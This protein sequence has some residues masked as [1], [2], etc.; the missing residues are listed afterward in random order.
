VLRAL[1]LC[2]PAAAAGAPLPAPAADTRSLAAEVPAGPLAQALAAFGKQTG[3][4]VIYVAA[5]ADA[6]VSRGARAGSAL[7]DAL[8]QLLDGTGLRFEF[9]NPRT[10]RVYAAAVP[11]LA[12]RPPAEAAPP[13]DYRGQAR[14]ATV[15]EV[16]VTAS[17]REERSQ[18]VPISIQVLTGETLTRLNASTFDDFVK[19]LPGITTQGAGPAQNN[20]VIRGLATAAL[21]QQGSGTLGSFPNVAVYLDEQSVELA[22]RNLDVY[23][24][25]LERIEVLEGPQGTLF[26]SGAQAGVVRYITNKPKLDVTEGT[27]S[28]ALGRTTH[29]GTSTD[30]SAVINAPL[31]P[32]RLA[33]RGVLYSEQRAGYIDNVSGT[34]TRAS[35]D[36]A[37]QHFYT[38]WGVLPSFGPALD[39]AAVV[40]AHSNP[41]A[42]HGL[43]LSAL[44]RFNDDWSALLAQSFQNIDADG[45][46]AQMAANSAGEPLPDLSVQEFNRSYNKD[47]FSNTALTVS[48]RIGDV[49]ILYAGAYLVRHVDQVQDYTSYARASYA[50]YYQCIPLPS[51]QCF[52][53]SGVWRELERNTRQ[54]HELR[55]T[56]PADRRVRGVGGLYFEELGVEEQWDDDIRSASDFFNPMAPPTGYCTYN[57]S[58]TFPDGSPV[59]CY[60]SPTFV[61]A[62]ATSNNPSVRPAVDGFF[63][64]ITRRYRQFAAFASVDADIVPRTLT[65]TAGTRYFRVEGSEVGSSVSSYGC[66][67]VT[68]YNV[69]NPC[70]N[71][72]AFNLDAAGLT[73]QYSGF[74][75]RLSLGWRIADDALIYY[76]WSQGFRAG[77]FNRTGYPGGNSPLAAEGNSWQAQAGAHGGWIA[78]IAFAPDD[79]TNNELGWKS[80]WLD[81]RLRW[82]GAV[83]QEHWDHAQVGVAGNRLIAYRMVIDGG[84]YR[85]RG[86]E[87]SAEA[88]ILRG[89][90][91][92]AS[93]AWNHTELVRQA[94][95]YWA[96]GTPVDFNSLYFSDGTRATNPSGELGS[97]LAGAP[98]FAGNARIRYEFEL[99]PFGA[100]AQAGAVWQAHS[101][102]STDR[103]NQ[104][105]QGHSTAYD[106]PAFTTFEAAFGMGKGAWQLKINGENLTDTRAQ[107][108]ASYAQWYKAVTV[109][110]PRTISMQLDYH[111]GGP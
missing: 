99:G 63:D 33:V 1:A 18:D 66:S 49:S 2:A 101:I 10:V 13:A 100:F 28:A 50:D 35:S 27:L 37:M 32:E 108:Y 57:G 31:I 61:H 55:I 51:P 95:F 22:H 67:L 86:V 106:L 98:S 36:P 81:Q 62:P 20:I 24:V 39:N 93:A 92:D 41:V 29:G 4:Q 84:D 40:H 45:V 78:P 43:R 68:A 5:L 15:D 73:R 25:D 74:R 72:F 3:V 76:T 83:Y 58:A 90:T 53:P 75:S 105:L 26:G 89:L 9:L 60:S 21:G 109:N 17:R 34:F 102:A 48:G 6:K 30:G 47:R 46:F 80:Q 44:Y 8:T 96:D 64:D 70:V 104:D 11:R 91:I 87:T 77:S 52:T 85:V 69:P 103:L 97:S 23:A 56:T 14:L 71:G 79:L 94:P 111:F 19:Y 107:L 42:Y 88:R 82:D 16:V 38:D 7:A 12:V 65:L 110:R 59:P 54:S